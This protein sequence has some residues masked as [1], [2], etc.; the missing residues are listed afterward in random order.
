MKKNSFTQVFVVTIVMAQI[1]ISF[2]ENTTFPLRIVI[3]IISCLISWVGCSLFNYLYS[4]KLHDHIEWCDT[5]LN[6]TY[7][8]EKCSSIKP[9]WDVINQDAA[10]IESLLES[11]KSSLKND[12][13]KGNINL[14]KHTWLLNSE[15]YILYRFEEY[16]F[17]IKLEWGESFCG[18]NLVENKYFISTEKKITGHVVELKR[19]P[20]TNSG[21]T[22][23]EIRYALDTQIGKIKQFKNLEVFRYAEAR[24][25]TIERYLER[26][27]V[28]YFK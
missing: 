9:T 4:K 12:F 1:A 17:N 11:F 25:G 13:M 15:N 7:I 26:K 14:N 16:C 18:H 21:L 5:Y 3:L 19:Y 24:C 22:L 10:F 8:D 2:L 23:L 20:I 6:H 27:T 28:D